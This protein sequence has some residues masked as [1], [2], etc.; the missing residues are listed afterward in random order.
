MHPPHYR[1]DGADVGVYLGGVCGST[2]TAI[3]PWGADANL[4]LLELERDPPHPW[5]RETA[6][7]SVCRG[8]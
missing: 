4:M 8:S 2:N 6:K 1:D 7:S 3:A 5:A